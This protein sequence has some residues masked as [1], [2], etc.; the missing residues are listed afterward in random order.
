M[1]R[2]P[3][4]VVCFSD[5]SASASVSRDSGG[6]G[7]GGGPGGG[8]PKG[9]VGRGRTPTMS[10]LVLG[11]GGGSSS[12]VVALP[13]DG[14]PVSRAGDDA[15][16]GPSCTSAH[17]PPPPPPASPP[18]APG[19]APPGAD[20][21]DVDVDGNDGEGEDDV[22]TRCDACRAP[23]RPARPLWMCL[24]CGAVGCG[25]YSGG[26][27]RAHHRGTGHPF[28]VDLASGRVWD[29]GGDDW[30]H[31]LVQAGSSGRPGA[32]LRRALVPVRDPNPPHRIPP[33]PR[34]WP[35]TICRPAGTADARPPRTRRGAWR[36]AGG[37]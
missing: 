8:G 1:S 24:D 32:Q 35:T 13:A 7:N 37:G 34:P 2:D 16:P 11:G 12:L 19:A 25:R 29:Y 10:S 17:P 20:L 15:P 30:V 14:P 18:A 23:L 36:A 6:D 3:D 31:R 21:P 5:G 22:A 4:I 9:P 28:A 27:A 33:P 26:H